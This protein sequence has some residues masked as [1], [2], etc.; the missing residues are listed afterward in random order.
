MIEFIILYFHL[1]FNKKGDG[2]FAQTIEFVDFH[3]MYS[4]KA[5][6]VQ[7]VF[8]VLE[9]DLSKFVVNEELRKKSVSKSGAGVVFC[10]ACGLNRKEEP[11][12]GNKKQA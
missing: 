1:H 4:V 8:L 2:K 3:K 5:G 12:A 6:A 10:H 11:A 7:H 9:K